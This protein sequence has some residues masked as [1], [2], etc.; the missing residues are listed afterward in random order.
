MRGRT[1]YAV[2]PSP[3]HVRRDGFSNVRM[4]EG[5]LGDGIWNGEGLKEKRI[6]KEGKAI[7]FAEL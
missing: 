5:R 4:V 2:L 3:S 7:L 6:R 1:E